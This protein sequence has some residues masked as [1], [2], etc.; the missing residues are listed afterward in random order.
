MKTWLPQSYRRSI[1]GVSLA[2]L[3]PF[4]ANA[5]HLIGGNLGY[6]GLGETSPGSGTYAY[7]VYMEF[8]LNCGSNSNFETLYD[9]LGQDYGTPL[10]VGVYIQD[11]GDPDADKSQLQEI[12]LFLEDSLV[13]VPD[14]PDGCT[15]GQ[16]L[17][18]IRGRF[19][20]TLLA[21]LNFG[22]YHLYYQQCCRNL[23]ITNLDNPNG[24]GIGY[25][26]FIPPT[27][28]QNSSPIF[29][30]PPTPFLCTSDTTT[31]VNT[32]I[33]PDGDLLIFSF[34]RPYNSTTTN[35]GLIPPP[36]LLQWPLPQVNYAGGFNTLQ[37]FGSTGYSFISGSTGLTEYFSPSQG[38]FVVAVE[39]KE[40]RNGQLIGISR[41]DLQ[42]QVVACPPNATPA[43][44]APIQL[45]YQVNAGDQLCFDLDFLDVDGDTLTLEASGAIFDPNFFTP[46]ATI[47]A[48]VIGNGAV[49]SQFCWNTSCDQGQGQPY[50]FSVSVTDNGCPPKTID[51]VLSVEV[52]PFLGPT[53]INGPDQVCAL[54]TGTTYT[55]DTLTGATYTWEV[56][57]GTIVSGGTTAAIVV[58]W[59]TPGNGSV[60]VL[61]TDQFSCISD[62]I[63]LDVTIAALPAVDAGPD[64]TICATTSVTLGGSPTG[65]PGS[66]YQWSPGGLNNATVANPVA[67]PTASTTY[68]VQVN[69]AGCSA[70][71]TVVVQLSN[72]V[73][74]VTNDTTI[75]SGASVPLSASGGTTYTWTP[76]TGLSDPNVADPIATPLVSTLYTVTITDSLGC[77]AQDSVSITVNELP[78]ADAGTDTLICEGVG[79]V[80]GGSPTGPVG[81]LF[82]WT[83]AGNLDNATVSNPVA[84]SGATTTYAVLVIDDNGCEATDSVTISIL[85]GPAL[86]AGSDVTICPGDSVQLQAS[87]TGVHLWSPAIGLNDP[88]IAN[89]LASPPTTTT[90]I[91]SLEDGSTCTSFDTLQVLVLP[92]VAADAGPSVGLCLGDTAQLQATG[93]SSYQW[94]PAI[95]LSA[96]NVPD[97]LAFPSV[98]TTYTV[99]VTD[100]LGCV[101]IDSTTVT[102]NAPPTAD[103]GADVS[104]CAGDNSVIGGAP[105]GPVGSS[106]LWSPAT[107]LDNAAIANPT[108]NATG[109]TVYTVTVVDTNSCSAVDTM[110]VTVAP[111]PFLEA[112]ED[113]T[114]CEN[115]PVQLN[116]IG[117][118]TFDWSPAT[119]L[120]ATN[121]SDPIATPTA[122][123]TYTVSLTDSL[124]CTSTDQITITVTLPLPAEAGPDVWVCPGFA[125]QLQA[126]AG[127]SHSWTPT[128]GL[129]DPTIPDP[130]AMP[131][132]TT[133]YTVTISD[134]NGCVSSDSLTVTVSDDPPVNAGPDQSIC[135]GGSVLIGGAPS[136]L[137]GASFLWTPGNTLNDSTLANPLAS[138]LADQIYTLTVT[139]DTCT[140]QDQVLVS[141]QGSAQ[142]AFSVRFE[143]GCEGLRAFFTN[144][145]VGA[146]SYSW[147]L[148]D[149]TTTTETSP[150]HLY[151]YGASFSITLT[152]T[153]AQGCIGTVT[154]TYPNGTYDDLVNI[155][156]PNIFTPNDDGVNDV[157]TLDSEAFLGPCTSM[158]IYNRW[159][160]KVFES[161][162]NNITWDGY[163]FAGEACVTGTYFYVI[164]VKDLTFEGTVQLN[165]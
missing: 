132:S 66:T 148:G 23:S 42:L 88:G 39:V 53:A 70:T 57:G 122:D 24:T 110:V 8:Y 84:T 86:D 2:L 72:A 29:I 91:V 151:T 49:S 102:V 50:L 4:G 106:F 15:V 59:N 93:G 82:T 5:T 131:T 22:G 150:Q 119:G 10:T 69:S 108:A 146:V 47:D 45:A 138:P 136:G 141:L 19:T 163:T 34:E 32:A 43:P 137:P 85:N 55:T 130:M 124:G 97:P 11:P 114:V 35:G 25:Y 125:V 20:G 37:P 115:T 162:G 26:A 160:Q 161:L 9:L 107:G 96:T 27:L 152:V 101:G 118:G 139:N 56:N 105:T 67:T 63:T 12:Q 18:T 134:G 123:I 81:A 48:P 164:T 6:V 154:Q 99:I 78:V 65:P 142:A 74:Q 94:S 126:S 73:P 95:G 121:I 60:S 3:L 31:F 104:Y 75:C 153:D 111:L 129:S 113:T 135:I 58:D 33:D 165:R 52:I 40:Y 158:F 103:A 68:I 71:D 1:L 28:V 54:Q 149:G 38:N 77:S 147:D 89:P 159:G 140:S 155:T 41:R 156:V 21:P 80:L 157:F 127:A 46:P 87:G 30:G 117:N 76:A 116:A 62:T 83:P 100:S 36:A 64:T 120:S 13:I 112:G 133:V 14:L 92:G 128:T 61:A 145:S 44:A 144:E 17:C 143:P 7:Q 98:T 16:S 109:T 90:Y 79:H 51:V